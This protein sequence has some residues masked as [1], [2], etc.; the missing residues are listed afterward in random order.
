M[1]RA[2]GFT[3]FRALTAW[4]ASVGATWTRPPTDTQE[5]NDMLKALLRKREEGFTLV[6]LMIVVAIIGVLAALAIYGVSR[7]LKHSKTA[8]ATRNLAAMENGSKNAYQQETDVNGNGTGPYIHTFCVSAGPQPATTP[9]AAKALGDYSTSPAADG[10]K[11]LKFSVNEPQFYKYTYTGDTN[12]SGTDAIYTATAN[13]DLDGNGVESSF[14]LVGQGGTSGDAV[15]A[16]F[17]VTNE[18]E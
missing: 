3:P 6:E 17:K 11:C 16:S 9:K 18:D 1:I 4:P 7:Y 8:E 13:G 10:W 14:V 12:K 15:R 5:R 2:R